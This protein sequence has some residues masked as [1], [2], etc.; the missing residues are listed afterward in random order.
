MRVVAFVK[1]L[2]FYTVDD[3]ETLLTAVWW[4]GRVWIEK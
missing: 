3:K 2:H 4:I 1:Y